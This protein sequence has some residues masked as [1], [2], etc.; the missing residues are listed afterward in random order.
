MDNIENL[1]QKYYESI[2]LLQN[3]QDILD[4]L[5]QPD[6]RNFFQLIT[7]LIERLDRERITLEQELEFSDND[8]KEYIKEEIKNLLLKKE[9]CNELL[10]H[11]KENESIEEEPETNTRK[12]IIFATTESGNICIENDIK[13][14]P[15][16]YFEEV[17]TMLQNLQ[18]GIEENNQEKAKTMTTVNK[19]MAGI[20][21]VKE[22]KVRLYYKRL[23]SDTVYAL[24]VRM[25]KSDNDALD[26]KEAIR[27][28]TQRQKQYL[29]LKNKIKDPETKTQLI[30]EHEQIMS[31]LCNYLSKNKRGK[32]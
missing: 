15:E 30:A 11:A 13:A 16:E 24:I 7:G 10:Q 19:K 23:S 17:I 21:S 6:Y 5:P 31:N 12:N 2:I 26:R 28:A 25:K 18:N 3:K 22:F 32:Q 4:A 20:H 9:I 29:Q 27:R 1:R 14:L 8:M